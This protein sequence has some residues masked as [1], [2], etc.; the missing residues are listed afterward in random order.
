MHIPGGII[1]DRYGGKHGVQFAVA[2][3]A[4]CSFMSELS[5]KYGGWKLFCTVRIIVG[6]SQVKHF[7]FVIS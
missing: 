3:S 2:V 5:I 6:L 1:A 4:L 7:Y